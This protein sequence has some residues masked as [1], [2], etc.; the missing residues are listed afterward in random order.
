MIVADERARDGLELFENDGVPAFEM[1]NETLKMC[2]D[3]DGTLWNSV[4]G[5][6]VRDADGN[7]VFS[8]SWSDTGVCGTLHDDEFRLEIKEEF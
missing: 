3:K 2:A 4:R 6:D 1:K 7:L 8:L 5:L